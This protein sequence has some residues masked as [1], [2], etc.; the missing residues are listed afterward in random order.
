MTT[1][2]FLDV[3]RADPADRAD[4][5]LTTAQR[6]GAPLINIEKDFWVCWTLNTLYHRLPKGGPRLLF[7]GGTSL[8]KA[9]GLVSRFSEDIEVTVFREDLGHPKS[10]AE[11][12]AL[13]SKKRPRRALIAWVRCRISSSRTRKTLAA[14]ACTRPC[15]SHSRACQGKRTHRSAATP[16][17]SRASSKASQR[18]RRSLKP[19]DRRDRR[20]G[21]FYFGAFGEN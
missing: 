11:I 5:F 10:T 16:Q 19:A 8:S 18:R 3:I 7:K 13:S 4:L 9:Y 12:A 20:S 14:P 2:A 21:E 17:A 6:L 1:G 15:R